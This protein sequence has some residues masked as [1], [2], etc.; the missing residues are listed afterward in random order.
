MLPAGTSWAPNSSTCITCGSSVL[1]D[2]IWR[3]PLRHLMGVQYANQRRDG[4]NGRLL[5]SHQLPRAV[6]PGR[7]ILLRADFKWQ[8]LLRR[9]IGIQYAAMG[10]LWPNNANSKWRAVLRHLMGVQYAAQRC[11]GLGGGDGPPDS[12]L[13]PG[14]QPLRNADAGN[15]ILDLAEHWIISRRAVLGL[16]RDR[17]TGNRRRKRRLTLRQHVRVDVAAC[18]PH[19]CGILNR[20]HVDHHI[21]GDHSDLLFERAQE[22]RTRVNHTQDDF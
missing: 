8:V 3:A 5:L 2:F 16:L 1:A 19:S 7:K 17:C 13:L 4:L 18:A 11:D 21:I 9:H 6:D 12:N 22:P 20:A 15:T 10:N 14:H